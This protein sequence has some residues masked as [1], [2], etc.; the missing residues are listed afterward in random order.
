MFLSRVLEEIY[1]QSA[2]DNDDHL[3][4]SFQKNNNNNKKKH[5]YC[6]KNDY[7]NVIFSLQESHPAVIKMKEEAF[8][9]THTFSIQMILLYE[10]GLTK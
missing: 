9:R 3:G 7:K 5:G 8:R 4:S 10:C 1:L 2:T 6:N